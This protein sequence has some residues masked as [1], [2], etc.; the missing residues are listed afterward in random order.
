MSKESK[1]R[2]QLSTMP[3]PKFRPALMKVSESKPNSQVEHA[4]GIGSKQK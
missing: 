1:G 2:G 4:R 3:K